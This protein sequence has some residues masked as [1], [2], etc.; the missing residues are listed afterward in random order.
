MEA[1]EAVSAEECVFRCTDCL[2]PPADAIDEA[3][4]DGGSIRS[5]SSPGSLLRKSGLGCG[6]V[7]RYRPSWR[8]APPS[9]GNG[10]LLEE[11]EQYELLPEWR[12]PGTMWS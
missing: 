1:V 6:G 11:A 10:Q 12:K 3:L 2:I 7:I 4:E 5:A 9:L 8:P